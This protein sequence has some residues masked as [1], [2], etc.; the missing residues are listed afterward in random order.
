MYVCICKPVTDRQIRR[1]IDEGACCM[2]DLRDTLGVGACCGRCVPE[3]KALL[4]EATAR[5]VSRLPMD[6]LPMAA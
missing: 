3:A 1:A 6:A 5:E 2:R 4:R